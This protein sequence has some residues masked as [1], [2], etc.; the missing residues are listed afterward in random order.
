M[1]G[2]ARKKLA[3]GTKFNQ[4]SMAAPWVVLPVSPAAATTEVEEDIDGGPPGS[5]CRYLRQQPPPKLKKMSMAGSL[6]GAVG[7]SS[8]SHH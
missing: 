1:V 6:G 3:A 7:I 4:R 8:S 2:V 5:C